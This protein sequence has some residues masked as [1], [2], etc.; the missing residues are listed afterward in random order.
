MKKD[1]LTFR[2]YAFQR[3]ALP[4]QKTFSAGVDD[5]GGLAKP[6]VGITLFVFLI[7]QLFDC[8]FTIAHHIGRHPQQSCAGGSPY[9]EHA[10]I[11]APDELF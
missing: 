6:W 4:F 2:R 9:N 11:C 8:I 1:E 3:I 10:D 7:Y 5:D